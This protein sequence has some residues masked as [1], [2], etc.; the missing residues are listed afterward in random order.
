MRKQ[1]TELKFRRRR[2]ALTNYKKRFAL[3]KSGASR[4]VVRK[5]NKRIIAQVASYTEQGD[6]TVAYVD[7]SELKKYGWPARANRP[8]A[9]LTGLLLGKKAKGVKGEL[10]L[11]IGLSSPVPGSI[12][13]VFAKG[14]I[15]AGLKVK[16]GITIED[17]VYNYTNTDYAKKLKQEDPEGYKRQYGAYIEAKTEPEALGNLFSQTKQ[18]ILK[19]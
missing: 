16:A 15:D 8:T 3:V 13:F 4:I 6:K 18:K 1:V 2:E 7:S 11:D 12:P 14:C 17:K 19:E 5:T 9:Y 10:I